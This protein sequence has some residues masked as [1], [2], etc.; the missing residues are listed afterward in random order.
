M[1]D[2][3]ARQVVF[4]PRDHFVFPVARRHFIHT[5]GFSFFL[6]QKHRQ[7]FQLCV[8]VAAMCFVCSH[9]TEQPGSRCSNT[10]VVDVMKSSR[11]HNF[12][13]ICAIFFVSF[14]RQASV[15]FNLFYSM[16][17]NMYIY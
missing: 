10:V 15:R 3:L 17:Q 1:A 6:L 16:F 13:K 14:V 5:K 9:K 8:D 7:D 2:I 4:S 12:N 11:Y